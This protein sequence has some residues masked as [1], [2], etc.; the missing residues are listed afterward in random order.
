MKKKETFLSLIDNK[1][2]IEKKRKRRTKK[3]KSTLP[4]HL[5]VNEVKDLNKTLKKNLYKKS[6]SYIRE[7]SANI[8]EKRKKSVLKKSERKKYVLKKSE[9]KKSFLKKSERKNSFMQKS[10][11]KKLNLKYKENN[12]SFLIEKKDSLKKELDAKNKSIIPL[13]KKLENFDKFDVSF[14]IKKKIIQKETKFLTDDT[15]LEITNCLNPDIENNEEKILEVKKEEEIKEIIPQ[16]EENIIKPEL[17]FKILVIG[18]SNVG[19][20]NLVSRFCE[21]KFNENSKTTIGVDFNLYE[22]EIDNK[23]ITAQF[24]DTAGQE[25]YRAMSTAFYKKAEGAIIVY[26][27]SDNRSF[28]NINSWLN[29]IKFYAEEKI[30]IILLGNKSDLKTLDSVPK[31]KAEEFAKKNDLFFLE[32][33]AKENYDKKVEKGF[34]KI[35]QMLADMPVDVKKKEIIKKMI[36]LRK[37]TEVISKGNQ[38]VQIA[39]AETL[40]KYSWNNMKIRVNNNKCCGG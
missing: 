10:E 17:L 31:K 35:L 37:E 33:S 19:K 12:K 2:S 22:T 14:V 20:T 1:S 8:K 40:D 7:K 21:N 15:I 32:V 11:T 6:K 34:N 9:S 29:E 13:N 27:I 3:A 36:V 24:W 16:E 5:I 26:D 28:D 4:D 38:E 39:R 23:K 25:K 30:K 18:D